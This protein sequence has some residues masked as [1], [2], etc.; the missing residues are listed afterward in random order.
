MRGLLGRVASE[1]QWLAATLGIAVV[2]WVLL[3]QA[4]GA[5]L[6]AG[7]NG[8][9]VLSLGFL[10]GLLLT[11][12]WLARRNRPSEA[13]R[14]AVCRTC[15]G[16]GTGPVR[17]NGTKVAC[18]WCRGTG[19]PSYSV[20]GLA[21][22]VLLV[23]L[24]GVVLTTLEIHQATRP[25]WPP[26]ATLAPPVATSV[27]GDAPAG[28]VPVR[29]VN[30]APAEGDV[31][32]RAAGHEPTVDEARTDSTLDRAGAPIEPVETV[33]MA[34]PETRSEPGTTPAPI[35]EPVLDPVPEVSATA[36]GRR[37]GLRPGILPLDRTPLAP[38]VEH[39]VPIP[40]PDAAVGPVPLLEPEPLR[41]GETRV[42]VP[43]PIRGRRLAWVAKS[44]VTADRIAT[45]SLSGTQLDRAFE[46]RNV[47]VV[48]GRL[49]V[50]VL[51]VG[52]RSAKVGL[53]RGLE[54]WVP[55]DNLAR[56]PR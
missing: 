8:R 7:L 9:H 23:C 37:R 38:P 17:S 22:P 39:A 11:L 34:A 35:D 49:N 41:V 43:S 44:E 1:V 28:P 24:A 42:L 2:A 40:V 50:Q 20:A 26:D 29:D 13:E 33:A 12:G 21:V 19:R 27:G 51:A 54:G 25:Q 31:A 36:A 53:E 14:R 18:P 4:T 15:G 16:T 5:G 47:A 30:A 6:G 55:T 3:I 32:D 45:G 10:Y 52:K 46:L 56:P 48:T